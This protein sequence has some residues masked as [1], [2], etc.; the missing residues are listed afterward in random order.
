[1]DLDQIVRWKDCVP[2]TRSEGFRFL[3]ILSTFWADLLFAHSELS[4][5]FRSAASNAADA[6]HAMQR[7]S[8][9]YFSYKVVLRCLSQV[10]VGRG[11]IYR[12]VLR[13]SH[14]VSVRA[15]GSVPRLGLGVGT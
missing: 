7:T 10:V 2:M 11:L 5:P 15:Q 12:I 9:T 14:S 8:V 13:S 6:V 1:M 4:P 3:S